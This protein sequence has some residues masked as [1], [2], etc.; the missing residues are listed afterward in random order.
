MMPEMVEPDKLLEDWRVMLSIGMIE[1]MQENDTSFVPLIVPFEQPEEHILLP[2]LSTLMDIKKEELPNFF[3]I[4]P[5]SDQVVPYPEELKDPEDFSPE[6]I[7]L[8]ARRTILYLEI[9]LFENEIAVYDEKVAKAEEEIP[10]W[11]TEKIERARNSLA[12]ALEE[13]AIVIETL[14]ESS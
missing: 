12:A 4:H 2:Q 5:F 7:L 10:E 14:E 11:E 13:K 1:L 3:A 6:L 9:E 8:W